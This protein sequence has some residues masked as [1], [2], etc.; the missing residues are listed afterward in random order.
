MI[1]VPYALIQ[2]KREWERFYRRPTLERKVVAANSSSAFRA[3]LP[4]SAVSCKLVWLR[5]LSGNGLLEGINGLSRTT[6]SIIRH[7]L[8]KVTFF[9]R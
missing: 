1:A 6:R 8:D 4:V 5:M 3:K 9:T 7:A 2:L